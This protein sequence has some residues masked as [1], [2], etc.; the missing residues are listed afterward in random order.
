MP[1]LAMALT[2]GEVARLTGRAL[3]E[4]HLYTRLAIAEKLKPEAKS[5]ARAYRISARQ[6]SGIVRLPPC[7]RLARS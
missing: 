1:E 2:H 6:L 3:S 4:R 5:F 7:G